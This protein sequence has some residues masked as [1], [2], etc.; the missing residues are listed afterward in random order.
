MK[1]IDG[2]K[3]DF[4]DVL[5]LPKRSKAV[6]RSEVVVTRKFKNKLGKDIEVVPII[7]ANMDTV[8]TFDMAV[9]LAKHG[10]M[11]ALHKHYTVEEYVE[12]FTKNQD[13]SKY[14]FYSLG[15]NEKDIE[16]LKAVQNVCGENISAI[17]IDV[18]NGY[19]DHFVEK[20]KRIIAQVGSKFIMAGNV[21]TPNMVEELIMA[22]VDIVK[23]GI[24]PGSACTTRVKT[25]VGY[26]QLS[27]VL[28][29]ADA[30]H[31]MNK[32]ICSD[33]GCTVPG[34]VAKAFGANADFVML[35]GM[36]AGHKECNGKVITKYYMGDEVIRNNSLDST[37]LL[38]KFDPVVDE[39]K[40]VEFY[41]MSSKVAQEKHGNG[42]AEY[43]ASEGKSVLVPYRGEVAGTIQ[44]I[45]GGVR[46]CCT[47]VGTS[48]LKDLGKCTT[49]IR[50]S[51]QENRV[52]G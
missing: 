34:D 51:V 19:T 46:S 38:K 1:I 15:I 52:F 20:V 6:S 18:A 31:G 17:C 30:A 14:V 3:L 48:K 5:I 35:G 11:T 28:E 32:Y 45:L 4:K 41:G 22:G 23:C 8:A 40:F 42:L 21:V 43:K 47:Y 37:P 29:C 24:G 9:A 44:E 10:C 36:L 49:F 16:K 50:S 2:L 39:K 12:F 26:P 7:A 27:C 33:G 13:I 25:G